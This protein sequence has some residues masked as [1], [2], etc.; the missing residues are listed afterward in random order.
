MRR[1]CSKMRQAGFTLIELMIVVAIVS[2]LMA[3]GIPAYRDH[4][5]SARRADAT[6][7]LVEVTQFMERNFSDS[8]RYDQNATGAAIT[9]PVALQ[10][11]PRGSTD[12]TRYYTVTLTGLSDT[13]FTAQAVPVNAQSTDPCGTLTLNHRG[14]RT[15][16]GVSSTR[17]INTCWR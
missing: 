11:T 4:V 7:M 2:I 1:E 14:Q 12:G 13:A 15:A 5:E 10:G 3:I 6:A 16:S 9:L 8:G 17:P